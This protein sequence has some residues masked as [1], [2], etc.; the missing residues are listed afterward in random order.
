MDSNPSLTEIRNLFRF[1]TK[2]CHCSFFFREEFPCDKVLSARDKENV[3][4]NRLPIY[5]WQRLKVSSRF[6]A[7]IQ[8]R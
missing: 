4:K 3:V 7:R 5:R 6:V 8:L 1:F 2:M